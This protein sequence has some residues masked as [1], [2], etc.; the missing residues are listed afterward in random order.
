MRTSVRPPSPLTLF[1]ESKIMPHCGL[2][3]YL[4]HNLFSKV[5]SIMDRRRK[6]VYSGDFCVIRPLLFSNSLTRVNP[7]FAL[8]MEL[9]EC[10]LEQAVGAGLR[11]TFPE[12]FILARHMMLALEA[13][14]SSNLV[15]LDVKQANIFIKNRNYKVDLLQEL[16]FLGVLLFVLALLTCGRI[17]LKAGRFWFSF[18]YRWRGDY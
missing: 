6:A 17:Y 16:Q 3:K 5:P 13:L 1:G 2:T 18:R 12:I 7:F 11:L 14:H 9:C 8:E 4:M 10:S 15:H